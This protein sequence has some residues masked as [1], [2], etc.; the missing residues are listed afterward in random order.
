MHSEVQEKL[1][2]PTGSKGGIAGAALAIVVKGYF[3]FFQRAIIAFLASA[4][5]SSRESSAMRAFPPFSPP[6][7]PRATAAGFFFFSG[8]LREGLGM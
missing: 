1:P 6:R 7:L 2:H 3:R 8:F 4:D 5:R